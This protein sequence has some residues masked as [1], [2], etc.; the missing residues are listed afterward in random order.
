MALEV[1]FL[2][3]SEMFGE[4]FIHVIRNAIGRTDVF[5][6]VLL[7]SQRRIHRD[8]GLRCLLCIPALPYLVLRKSSGV[9]V[10]MRE[11]NV[12]SSGV[13]AILIVSNTAL[14]SPI[15]IFCVLLPLYD[16]FHL[17]YFLKITLEINLFNY[18]SL[19]EM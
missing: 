12:Q 1:S 13:N 18:R 3:I 10:H 16:T 15:G 11:F 9:L 17:L 2:R 19:F 14:S 4:L 7:L 8:T 6:I 5:S